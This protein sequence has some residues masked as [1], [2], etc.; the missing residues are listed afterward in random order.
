MRK[1]MSAPGMNY[2]GYFAKV[3]FDPEDHIFVGQVLFMASP[4]LSL[5][6]LLPKL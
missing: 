1:T 2:K 6:Q 4:S 5:R 3:E